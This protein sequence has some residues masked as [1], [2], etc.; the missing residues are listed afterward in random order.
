LFPRASSS[1]VVAVHT[2][3]GLGLT[4]GPLAVAA[5]MMMGAW[6]AFPSSLAVGCLV[7]MLIA[8]LAR[9][10]ALQ[11][12][13]DGK[14]TSGGAATSLVFWMFAAIAILYAFAEGTFSNWAVIYLKES[15]QLPE[16]TAALALSVFWGALVAGR[17]L[18]SILVLKVRA[19]IVWSTLPVLMICAF[20]ALPYANGVAAGIGLFVLAG[21]ACSAFFPLTIALSSKC[22][23]N[24][25]A[26]V[27]SMLTAALM[28]GVG[29]GSFAVG[30]LREV[31]SL[32]N[33]YRISA[34]YPV[35]VLIL[36]FV[37]TRRRA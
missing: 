11:T 17:L 26:W 37:T 7:L 12:S 1:A 5:L 2:A 8:A 21:L 33:L 34:A 15:K 28:V 6:L 9:L 30:A 31:L 20:L 24:D 22:F 14:T 32:E 27:S 19:E 18:T 35:L 10:P 13:T 3:I 29:L 36:I 23:A 4:L 25:V 16:A